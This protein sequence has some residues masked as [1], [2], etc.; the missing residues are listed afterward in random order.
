MTKPTRIE[1]LSVVLSLSLVAIGGIVALQQTGLF[2][3][4]GTLPPV[5]GNGIKEGAE[6]CDLGQYNGPADVSDCSKKCKL[7]H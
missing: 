1:P 6:Q 3:A 7:N 5:C 2:A 4:V